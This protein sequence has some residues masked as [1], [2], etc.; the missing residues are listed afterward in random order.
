MGARAPRAPGRQGLPLRPRRRGHPARVAHP[1]RRRRLRGDD[2]RAGLP[3]GARGGGRPRRAAGRR[4]NPVRRRR[5]SRPS[6][7]RWPASS[8]APSRRLPRA[9]R[10]RVR[11]HWSVLRNRS[12]LL[13]LAASFGSVALI[14]LLIYPLREVVP[15]VSTG[16]VYTLAVLFVSSYWGLYLGLLTAVLGA[17]AWNFFHIPP[18][19]GFTISDGEN[20]VAL[21]VFFVAAAAISGLAGA[22]RARAEEAE[23]RRREADLTAEMARLLLGGTVLDESLRSAGR[24]IATAFDLASV[25]IELSWTDSDERRRALPLLVDGAR[26]GTVMVPRDIEPNVLDALQDRVLPSLETLVAAARKRDELEAQVIETKALRRS[27]VVKTAVLRSVSHDLRSPL[28]AITTAAAGLSSTTLS[29]EAR[30][31]LTS[32]IELETRPALAPGRQPARPVEAPGGRRRDRT[33]TGARSRSSCG[34]RS[35]ACAS[36]RAASTSRSTPA[37]R[38]SR[39]TPGSSSGR[40]RT[41]STTPPASR[42]TSRSASGHG[43]PPSRCCCASATAVPASRARSSSASSSRSTRRGRGRAPG[44]GS[45][46]RAASSRRTAGAS[47]PSRCPARGRRSCSACPCPPSSRP[48]GRAGGRMSRVLVCDDETQILRALRVILRDAGFEVITAQTAEEALDAASLRAPDAA[49]LDLI[50][51][52]GNGIDVVPLDPRVVADA[53]PGAVGGRRGAGEGA[54]AGRRRRR[55]R[56]QALR[57]RRADRPAERGAA[58]RGHAPRSRRCRSTASRSTSPPIA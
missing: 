42:A 24:Q 27:N 10:P 35:T 26:V 55:L 34:R 12:S 50:L 22:A 45:R 1:R 43:P 49:I 29:P 20:W 17:A 48:G 7:P 47:G 54:R 5:S 41:C 3:L 28:T 15:V 9:T 33:P 40:S 38:W 19:G 8:R 36:R 53:D 57:A 18:T 14:T 16:V 2:L 11:Q 51:P 30:A 21:G 46:S 52:D 6:S 23:T 37:C 58:A 56:D 13:G 31:E 25:S 4:R 32:V 44:S 39:P